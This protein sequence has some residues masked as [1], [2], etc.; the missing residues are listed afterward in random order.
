MSEEAQ[1]SPDRLSENR[2]FLLFIFSRLANVGAW[3]YNQTQL[4]IHVLVTRGFLR[5][6]ASL[7]LPP[8][9]VP[10]PEPD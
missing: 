6:L 4:R 7:E 2:D 10:P 1:A 9:R 8:A 3:L 5:S